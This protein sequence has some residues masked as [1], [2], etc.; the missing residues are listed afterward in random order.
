MSISDNEKRT[1]NAKTP[2][3]FLL[4]YTQYKS[5]EDWISRF[6]F[7]VSGYKMELTEENGISHNDS[8]S[9]DTTFHTDV[10]VVCISAG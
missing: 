6:I 3:T 10:S 5:T 4:E 1:K 2:D 7:F 8:L 9:D